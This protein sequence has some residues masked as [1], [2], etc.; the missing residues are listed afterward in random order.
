M[1]LENFDLIFIMIVGTFVDYLKVFCVS[2]LAGNLSDI[3]S[4]RRL[5]ELRAIFILTG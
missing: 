5:D 2:R 1:L 4:N 3:S